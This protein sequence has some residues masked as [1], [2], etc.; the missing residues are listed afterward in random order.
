MEEPSD[1]S[2]LPIHSATI[3]Y[4]LTRVLQ[5]TRRA[6]SALGGR[7]KILALHAPDHIP[8]WC[9]ELNGSGPSTRTCAQAYEGLIWCYNVIFSPPRYTCPFLYFSLPFKPGHISHPDITFPSCQHV[10]PAHGFYI[11]GEPLYIAELSWST[12]RKVGDLKGQWSISRQE[13]SRTA[14]MYIFWHSRC[15]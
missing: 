4:W 10:L 12:A 1:L 5:T 11:P 6:L 9:L 15:Q 13:G 14:G 7:A 8:K 2:A 3:G